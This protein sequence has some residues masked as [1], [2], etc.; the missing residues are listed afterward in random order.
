[1][2]GLPRSEVEPPARIDNTPTG[3]IRVTVV[4]GLATVL[5]G[6]AVRSNP[7]D[8]VNVPVLSSDGRL[9]YLL[10]LGTAIL[11]GV[12]SQRAERVR[13]ALAA[14]RSRFIGESVVPAPATAWI[15][16][17]MTVLGA[18]LLVA[19][20][21]RWVEI[22]AATMLA[23]SGVFA[24]LTVRENLTS[25]EAGRVNPARAAHV[26]LT[27]AVA[28][29]VL[30]LT[31]MFRMRTLISGPAVFIVAFLLL[32]QAHDGIDTWPIRKIAYGA[33]GALAL[34]EVTWGLNY[35]PPVGWYAGSILTA[36]FAGI[37]FIT[38]AQLTHAL[39]KDW[40][41]IAAASTAGMLVV[42]TILSWS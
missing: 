4:A 29:V 9:F 20:H 39:T 41:I 19:R 35:W 36:G 2:T 6:M 22:A 12:M 28:F 1:M 3:I 23:A 31:F 7:P 17:A 42:L 18:I 24:S 40:A 38:G 15:L 5:L 33:L 37:I 34:A 21:T 27:I 13:E 30:T 8:P 10:T 25:T 32:I 14:S 26:V 11:V 16:P